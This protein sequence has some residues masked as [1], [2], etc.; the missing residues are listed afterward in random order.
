MVD[1]DWK[2]SMGFLHGE[3][4][5]AQQEI[6]DVL[7]ND[8][9]TYDD[10]RKIILL[11]MKGRLDTSL[12]LAAYLLNPF[13]LYNDLDI[14]NDVKVSEAILD[15]FETLYPNDYEMQQKLLLEELP[16][17]TGQL[18][19]FDRLLAKKTCA[20]NDD[21]YDPANWWAAFG[22]STPNLKKIA[23]RILSLTTSSSGCERS[24]STFEGI[25][26]KKRNMLETTK[27]NNLV[28]VQ[29]NANMMLK[30]K[31]R[32]ERN[33]KVFLTD[34]PSEALDWV[35]DYEAMVEGSAR[36]RELY[37]EY[38]ESDSE[39]V[40]IADEDEYES[41]GVEIIEQFGKDQEWDDDEDI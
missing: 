37:D 18:E 16:I 23:I 3:L 13:Y 24:W 36:T 12:H 34:D 1:A 8:K 10:V 29:F 39:E 5:N 4:K 41:D 28:Y 9:K 27:L 14:Q 33:N 19:G 21:K 2:P 35:N 25:H 22:S 32:K 38:F 31:R 6:K 30:N 15:V 26:T 11:K 40:E 20:V 17:Y 7:N